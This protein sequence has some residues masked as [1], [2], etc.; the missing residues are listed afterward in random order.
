M[1][2]NKIPQIADYTRPR[3]RTI[4]EQLRLKFRAQIVQKIYWFL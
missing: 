1:L 3:P 4:S 2:S